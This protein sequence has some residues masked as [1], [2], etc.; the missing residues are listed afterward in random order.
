MLLTLNREKP[1]AAASAATGQFSVFC[2]GCPLSTCTCFYGAQF[3]VLILFF[4]LVAIS[5]LAP[6]IC[7]TYPSLTVRVFTFVRAKA[8]RAIRS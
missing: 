4:L 5:K 7:Q 1:I 3:A 2:D 6:C 8:L